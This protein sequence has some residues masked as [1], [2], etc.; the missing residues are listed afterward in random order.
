M[1]LGDSILST[2]SVCLVHLP[3]FLVWLVGIVLA[4]VHW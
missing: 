2:L 4:V 1:D 3:V